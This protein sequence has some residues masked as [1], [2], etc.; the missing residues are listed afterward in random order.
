M[1]ANF[2]S[3]FRKLTSVRSTWVIIGILMLIVAFMSF[4]LEGYKGVAGSAASNVTSLALAEIF[5]NT[6]STVATFTCLIAI[7][8]VGHEYRYNTIMYTLTASNSR[9]KVYLSKALT[10]MLFSIVVGAFV[11]VFSVGCY[12]LGLS[13]RDATLP[14]QTLS[15]VP[16]LSRALAY[17]AIYGLFGFILGI[18]LRSIIGAI[19]VFFLLPA[20]VEPLLRLLLK[21]K[22]DYLPISAFDHIIGAAVLPGSLSPN[23]ALITSAIYM[24][25]LLAVSLFL[26]QKRDAN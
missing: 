7:M 11:V 25:I 2:T 6:L 20:M 17:L 10:M 8:Q 5:K 16:D 4:W 19:A 3:D 22:A 9:L 24:V 18:L 26:F 12:F 13:L 1:L 23:K 21:D 15:L 14:A